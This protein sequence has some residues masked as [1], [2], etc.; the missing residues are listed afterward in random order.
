MPRARAKLSDK[1]ERILVQAQ[2]MGLST[3][4]MARISNRLKAIEKEQE[5]VARIND[6]IS[7]FAW[8]PVTDDKALK[9]VTPKGYTITAAGINLAST[10][11]YHYVYIYQL[12]ISKPGTRFKERTINKV[13]LH[14]DKDWRKRLLPSNSRE[15]Y[16]LIRWCRNPGHNFDWDL[17]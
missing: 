3:T 8:D 7:G 15:L 12:T 14:C 5:E 10:R 11:W 17:I 1:E 13:E 16:A 6:T 9:V 4:S 2:L